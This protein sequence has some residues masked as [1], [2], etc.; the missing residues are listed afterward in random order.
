MLWKKRKIR[1]ADSWCR[2]SPKRP[3]ANP[4]AGRSRGDLVSAALGLALGTFCALLPWYVFLH[5]D[6]FGVHP[7]VFEGRAGIGGV[8]WGTEQVA[9][10][11]AAM[12]PLDL[13]ATGTLPDSH[14]SP[15]RIPTEREQPFPT[16][17]PP[18]LDSAG[19]DTA[20]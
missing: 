18:L 14:A 3:D 20:K 2:W 16:A 13:L 5:Q 17:S 11:V 12:T 6:Q 9:A 1:E 8:G 4:S 7:L 15:P 19:V 10:A